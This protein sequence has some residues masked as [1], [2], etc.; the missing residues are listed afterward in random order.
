MASTEVDHLEYV[1]KRLS[2]MD[3]SELPRLAVDAKMTQ[4]TIYNVINGRAGTR[5]STVMNLY[6][7]L[8]RADKA[9]ARLAQ[10]RK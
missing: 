4:R 1:R 8:K 2:A 3:S 10:G 7:A 6:R 5:Y 9:K